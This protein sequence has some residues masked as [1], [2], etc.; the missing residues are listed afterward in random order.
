MAPTKSFENHSSK[1]LKLIIL[2]SECVLVVPPAVA[3]DHSKYLL[4]QMLNSSH[5]SS[6]ASFDKVMPS[7]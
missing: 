7:G 3:L 5:D 6:F 4:F 1:D 2:T